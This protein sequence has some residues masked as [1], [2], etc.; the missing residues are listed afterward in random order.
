MRCTWNLESYISFLNSAYSNHESLW[1][2]GDILL[3]RVIKCYL[4]S[5]EEQ[6]V[7]RGKKK[8]TR[9]AILHCTKELAVINKFSMKADINK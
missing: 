2:K 4:H 3:C 5:K 6:N 1:G 8:K 7:V 9:A